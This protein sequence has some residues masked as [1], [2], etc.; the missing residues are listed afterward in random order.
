MHP[1]EDALGN[2]CLDHLSL[3]RQDYSDLIRRCFPLPDRTKQIL[4]INE[5]DHGKAIMVFTIVTVIFLPLSFVTSYFGMN[6]SDIR[7]MNETQAVFWSV[8][9]PLACVTVGS[10]LLVGY[11]GDSIRELL[12]S[13]YRKIMGKEKDTIEA[14]GI[15][16]SQRQGPSKSQGGL[17]SL[18]YSFG[19]ANDGITRRPRGLNRAG[20][21]FGPDYDED[22]YD[23]WQ[24]QDNS[25]LLDQDNTSTY[26][27]GPYPSGITP[28]RQNSYPDPTSVAIQQRRHSLYPFSYPSERRQ[29][30]NDYDRVPYKAHKDV[31]RDY[32]P[33]PP[34]LPR[35]ARAKSGYANSVNPISAI[36]P[37]DPYSDRNSRSRLPD[38]GR[39]NIPYS[40][41]REPRSPP[42]RKSTY[43]ASARVHRGTYPNI[44]VDDS[45]F[46]RPLRR[47]REFSPVRRDRSRSRSRGYVARG[48]SRSRSRSYDRGDVRHVHYEEKP[49]GR[50]RY[51]SPDEY[52]VPY[53]ANRAG[54]RIRGRMRQDYER[55]ETGARRSSYSRDLY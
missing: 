19:P 44:D 33:P 38:Y 3:V 9:I 52:V 10:C 51:D 2:A 6:A 8:A 50:A 1:Y 27:Y 31:L 43:D 55:L 20:H 24:E 34:P 46:D 16:V 48:R 12:S 40:I 5:E 13:V 30:R 4:E 35:K 26:P 21:Y 41:P 29:S 49:A 37:F 45:I 42:R 53:E 15:T 32:P 47:E 39:S 7:D 28:R 36:N 11:N 17:D 25:R 14:A 54:D 22:E 23:W 18:L